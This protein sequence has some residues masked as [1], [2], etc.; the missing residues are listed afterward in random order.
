ALWFVQ[1]LRCFSVTITLKIFIR[2]EIYQNFT[3]S[4]RMWCAGRKQHGRSCVHL[5]FYGRKDI[6]HMQGKKMQKK[7]KDKCK[8]CML[9][10]Q[11]TTW[12]SLFL[13]EQKQKK[14]NLLG[15][16]IR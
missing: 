16:N 5:N 3:I 1:L 2:I 4:G 11:K 6:Q 14:K 15:L 10:S 7:K 13:K 12:Q 9:M 8:M